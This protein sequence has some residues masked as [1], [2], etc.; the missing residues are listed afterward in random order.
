MSNLLTIFA[1]ADKLIQGNLASQICGL[2]RDLLVLSAFRFIFLT[3]NA[4]FLFFLVAFLLYL[5]LLS[6][7]SSPAADKF[8][9]SFDK[10]LVTVVNFPTFD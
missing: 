9:V 7:T 8:L 6:T 4:G 2:A 10:S 5:L 3:K 1:D